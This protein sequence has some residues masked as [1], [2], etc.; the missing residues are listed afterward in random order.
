[1]LLENKVALITGAG[2]GIGKA[3]ALKMAAEGAVAVLT[4]RNMDSLMEVKQ[5][6]EE[7]G[8]RAVCYTCDVRDR[9]KVFALVDT[10]V[11][12]QGSIDILVNNAGISK[13]MPFME[14]PIEVFDEILEMN[15]RSVM[16][17]LKAVLPQ[18]EKQG[19]GSVVNI[20]SGAALR[21]LPGSAAYA[22]SKAA[23]VCLTQAVGDEVRSKGIR[24]NAICPG[25]VDTE[26]FRKS[27]R[28]DFILAAGGDLFQP[29]EVA[30]AAIF[31]ASDLSGCTNSQTLVM[32]GFNRW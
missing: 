19:G 13:E 2:R 4:G 10:I 16:L 23:V 17:V 21:G 28:R 12:E 22:A 3:I 14:M 15:L 30:N 5:E 29:E 25:P 8:G 7:A 26:L 1:M 27:E 18:M 32:R 24:I 6:I 20:G 9:E 11:E 31:L